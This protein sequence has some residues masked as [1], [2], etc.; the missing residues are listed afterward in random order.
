MGLSSLQNVKLAGFGHLD[1][2]LFFNTNFKIVRPF[3]I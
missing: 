1:N 3:L 2:S